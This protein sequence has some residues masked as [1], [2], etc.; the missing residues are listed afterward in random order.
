MVITRQVKADFLLLV[1]AAI[2]G[3]T[4]VVVKN[5]L[6]DIQP[7][8]FN[9]YRFLIA[10]IF[11]II[12]C[13]FYKIKF[14]GPLLK[15]GTIIGFFLF[16]GYSSQTIGLQYTTASN[17]GFITG[18]AVVFVPLFATIFTKKLPGMYSIAGA[19]LAAA[20]LFFL[21]VD[22]TLT[23]NIGDIITLF[24]AICFAVY[25]LLLG[26]YSP[27]FD[28]IPLVAM[29][30]FVVAFLSLICSLTLETPSVTMTSAIIIALLVC[31]IPATCLAFMIQTWAQ[32][33][34]TPTR[35]IIIITT[36]PVFAA[37]FAYMLLEE[38]FTTR[39]LLGAVLMLMGILL[40]EFKGE[41]QEVNHKVQGGV[42]T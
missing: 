33:F 37:L 30:I 16:L 42:D 12:I 32:K 35:T 25:I 8:T 26:K 40:V 1:V 19:I 13:I 6:D 15:I 2:W 7:F 18:L 34:T 14:D 38:I 28:T 5:A 27:Q 11:M 9:A 36:E 10:G 31:A 23:Y 41:T 22:S 17:S 20:G 24:G 29:Q 21:S 4:F 3:L 39:H